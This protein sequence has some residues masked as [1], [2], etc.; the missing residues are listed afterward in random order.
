MG[1]SSQG[2]SSSQSRAPTARPFLESVSLGEGR[3]VG[4]Q[5]IKDASFWVPSE[6]TPGI[7]ALREGTLSLGLMALLCGNCLGPTALALLGLK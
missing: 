4:H 2:R 6:E 3:K 7:R 5:L 1:S